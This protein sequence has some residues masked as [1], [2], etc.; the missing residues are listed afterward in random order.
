ML[1]CEGGGSMG[2]SELDN[3]VFAVSTASSYSACWRWKSVSRELSVFRAKLRGFC[4]GVLRGAQFFG[5][6]KL[7]AK[8]FGWFCVAE[9]EAEAEEMGA[10]GELSRFLGNK[11]FY[12]PSF[13]GKT[14]TKS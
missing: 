1:K 8:S 5:G 7:S 13:G 14:A 4:G 2:F 9:L 10:E 3:R 11:S 6:R 12:C